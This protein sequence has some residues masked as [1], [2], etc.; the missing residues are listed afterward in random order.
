MDYDE[1]F[2]DRPR[3]GMVLPTYYVRKD[4]QIKQLIESGF[5]QIE[6][7]DQEGTMVDNKRTAKDLFLHYMARKQD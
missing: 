5:W 3:P 6:V 4:A 7:I 2:T 1:C